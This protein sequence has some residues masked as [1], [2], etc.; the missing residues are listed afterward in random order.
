MN[1][2]KLTRFFFFFFYFIII[3]DDITSEYDLHVSK[4]A[5][6]HWA[7]LGTNVCT[8]NCKGIYARVYA[9]QCIAQHSTEHMS[10]DEL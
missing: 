4:I 6:V 2:S 10:T 9:L 3:S 8:T 1:R 5:C 7:E